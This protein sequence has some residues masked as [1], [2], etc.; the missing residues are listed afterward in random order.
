MSPTYIDPTPPGEDPLISQPQAR[1]ASRI[2]RLIEQRATPAHLIGLDGHWGAGK[3]NVIGIVK[4][5][6]HVSHH[7]FVYDAW[8]HQ[9]DLQRRTFLEELTHSLCVSKTIDPAKWT[10]KLQDLLARRRQTTTRTTPRLSVGVVATVILAALTPILKSVSEVTTT[11]PLLQLSISLLPLLTGLVMWTVGSLRARHLLRPNEVYRLYREHDSR[12]ETS[13]R[14]SEHQPSVRQFQSWMRDLS[15]DLTG[16]KLII[17]FD[18][19]DR[20]PSDRVQELWS[21]IHTFFAAT[22][23]PGVF[24]IVPFDL[25]R[26]ASALGCT[27]PEELLSKTFSVVF[28]VAPPVLTDWHGFFRSKFR[29]AFGNVTSDSVAEIMRIFDRLSQTIT[30]R[31]VIAF[32]NDLV[33]LQFTADDD[34]E[35]PYM[36]VFALACDKILADPIGQILSL[37]FLGPLKTEFESGNEIQDH[38]A[39]LAYH[40]PVP[41]ASQVTLSRAVGAMLA[42]GDVAVLSRLA[43]HAHFAEVLEE[44][45]S[46]DGIEVE[47]AVVVLN[48]FGEQASTQESPRLTRMWTA[49]GVASVKRPIESREFTATQRLILTNTRSSVRIALLRHIVRSIADWKEFNG[50]RYYA[51]LESLK[52]FAY[53]Q[54]IDAD[55]R[56]LLDDVTMPPD[57]L[58]QYLQSANAD[59]RTFMPFDGATVDEYVIEHVPDQL[60]GLHVLS[61]LRGYD[62]D[63]EPWKDALK[64][65]IESGAVSVQNVGPFYRFYRSIE[66]RGVTP[67]SDREIY[68]LMGTMRKQD[69]GYYD[70]VAMRI[71]RRNQFPVNDGLLYVTDREFVEAVADRLEYF[72]DY[73]EMVLGYFSWQSPLLKNVLQSLTLEPRQSSRLSI[74][75]ILP[76]FDDICSS[77]DIQPSVLLNRL[78]RSVGLA[79]EAVSSDNIADLV[80]QPGFFDIAVQSDIELADLLIT[81][82][83]AHLAT[84]QIDK[85]RQIFGD[86]SSYYFRVVVTLLSARRLKTLPDDGVAAYKEV[87][88]NTA[89]GAIGPIVDRVG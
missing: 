62:H 50:G 14:I 39:S 73:G 58:V 40:V 6:L 67:L 37:E 78:N 48:A 15:K 47:N 55:I 1:I 42:D 26:L 70:L 82:M 46:D 64:R 57:A 88:I 24:V 45:I 61:A 7:V 28:R 18:N 27:D 12:T 77:L 5:T 33:S 86:E 69:D 84:L 52:R 30:P 56:E 11:K 29:E 66:F 49:L 72:A 32:I 9:E 41:V 20:L 10:D 79:R 63:T 43:Q 3:S 25:Q 19:M 71:A 51:S 17:V 89:N 31:S 75:K 38:I 81:I 22:S 54:N 36:A 68:N 60:D 87:L 2:C 16:R 21:S 85:W 34:V 13:I 8:G 23:F 83:N 59:H 65:A 80:A 4:R 35:L 76:R 74:E 44:A 53:E